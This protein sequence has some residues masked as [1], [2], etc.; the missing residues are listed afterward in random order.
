M[1]ETDAWKNTETNIFIVYNNYLA[2][3]QLDIHVKNVLSSVTRQIPLL[4]KYVAAN[5][6]IPFL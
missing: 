2:G 6:V 3:S 1:A 4:K 5:W